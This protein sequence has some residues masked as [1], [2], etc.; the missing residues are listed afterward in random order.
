MLL[1]TIYYADSLTAAKKYCRFL[2]VFY[3]N[4]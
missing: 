1:G 2:L 4:E 3:V